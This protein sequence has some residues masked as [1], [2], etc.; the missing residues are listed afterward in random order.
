MTHKVIEKL[1]KCTLLVDVTGKQRSITVKQ[2]A[3]KTSRSGSK[4]GH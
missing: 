4:M 1:E 3:L 2:R